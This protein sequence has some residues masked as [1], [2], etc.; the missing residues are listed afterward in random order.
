MA[1]K[2]PWDDHSPRWKREKERQ[3][4]SKARWDS[5]LKL[6][7]SS[8]RIADPYKYAAGESVADQRR[9]LAVEAAYANMQSELGISKRSASINKN[10]AAMSSEELRRTAKASRAQLK[11]W[12]GKKVP[13]GSRNF[14]WY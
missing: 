11:R 3:G 13:P 9:A 2:K 12:A 5:Y 6:S 14:W 4:L 1:V 8:K 7:P 10:L